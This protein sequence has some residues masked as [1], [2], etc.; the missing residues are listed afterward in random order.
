MSALPPTSDVRHFSE[1]AG[2]SALAIVRVSSSPFW[3]T[4][5]EAL[6]D[7]VTDP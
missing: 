6:P 7:V 5:L 4:P 1:Q 2:V 3:L